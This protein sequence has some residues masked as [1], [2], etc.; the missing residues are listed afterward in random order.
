MMKPLSLILILGMVV[1]AA[2]LAGCTTPT[3]PE[4]TTGGTAGAPARMNEMV[5]LTEEYPPLNYVENGTVKGISVDLLIGAARQMGSPV[6]AHQ[7]S[8]LPWPEAYATALSRSNTVLFATVRLPERENLF[9]WAGPLGLEKKVVFSRRGD[10]PRIRTPADLNNYRI[11]VVKDDS[12]DLQLRSLGVNSSQII[13]VEN[14]PALISAMEKR[15]VDLWCY[16]ETAGR[17][18]SGKATGDPGYFKVVYELDAREL[19]Y[20]FHKDTPDGTVRAFQSA[21]DTLRLQPDSSGVT[22][23][24]RITYRY[25]GVSCMEEL[26]VTRDQV[27]GL[28]NY[29]AGEMVRD[30]PGTIAR[31]N[32][33]EHPFWDRENRAL[34]V[35]VYDTNVTIVAEADNQRLVGVNM[36]GKTD[37]AGIPFRSRIVEEALSLGTGWVGY[38]W[39]VP[40]ETGIYHKI[41]YF[42]LVQGSDSK[43]YIVI[44]GMYTSCSPEE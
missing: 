12:A 44:S 24:Q 22:E 13:P 39:M 9:K 40:E 15:S 7:I 37:V 32:A 8:V 18:F 25:S 16:G 1:C 30:A 33:G 3:T 2:L 14:V 29:T 26:P 43:P 42:R 11:G 4:T 19:W 35:F 21:L 23:Y 41:A 6:S 31:I 10:S 34:Y 17:Y 28:V 20:A 5:F 27:T 36:R 38:V